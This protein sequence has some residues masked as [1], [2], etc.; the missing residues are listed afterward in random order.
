MWMKQHLEGRFQIKTKVT[1]LGEEEIREERILHGVIHVTTEERGMK[2]DYKHADITVKNLNLRRAKGV[3]SP[4]EEEK[5]WEDNDSRVMPRANYLTQDP[6]D[7][8][9]AVKDI[10]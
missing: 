3:T 6:S 9:Y 1:G 4:C 5:S 2:A 10:C 8:Q 7:I